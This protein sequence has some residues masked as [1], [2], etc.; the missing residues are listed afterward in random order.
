MTKTILIAA[1]FHETHS[2]VEQGTFLSDFSIRRGAE[3]LARRGDA[4]TIDGF[5]EVA[6]E[7]EW[8][9]IPVNDYH[10]APAGPVDHAVFV[11][12]TNELLTALRQSL[13]SG[14]LDG[15]WLSLHGA[16]VTTQSVDVEG[17]L[18]R[19]IRAVPGAENLPIFG[20]F[21]LHAN[22]TELMSEGANCLVAYRENPHT[23]SRDMAVLSARL[24][25]R[26]LAEGVLPRMYTRNAPVMWAPPGTGT[27]DR[28]M[29]D[30]EALA[31]QI[32]GEGNGIWIANVIGG[33][34]FSDVPSAGVAFSVAT[35][36]STEDAMDALDRLERLA[37]DLRE[38]G[39]PPEWDLDEAVLEIKSKSNVGGPYLIVEPSDNIGGGAPGDDTAVLRAFLRHGITNAAVAIADA[40]AVAALADAQPG[41]KVKLTIGG[42][43]SALG[44]GPLEVEGIFLRRSDGKYVLEDRNS[45]IVASR[46][47]NIDMGPSAVI[48][49]AGVTILLS[50]DRMAPADLG[51]LR[52]Q[53]IIPETLKAVGIKA[54]VQHRRAYDKIMRGSYTVST[55]G[56]C[57]SK[58]TTLPYKRLRPNVFPF[59]A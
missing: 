37:I 54:A 32:E 13:A 26:S 9:V 31:R 16:H 14:P 24:L 57:T 27:A 49:V 43:G 46:G 55:P 25:A 19:M 4:S 8:T 18:L 42:K 12:F 23:D 38:L 44:A 30:L 59:D 2:F 34:S 35:T 58:I 10:A 5:L 51:Q 3:L 28:P 7:E 11:Q 52:S 40:E 53:G 41:E 17:D 56:P 1:L 33:Y 50:S 48:E 39:Q 21:D 6:D 47:V 29:K 15:I 20:V 36:G 22:F 45:H